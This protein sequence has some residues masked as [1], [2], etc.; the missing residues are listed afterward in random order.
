[1]TQRS[2][3][4]HRARQ[5][6]AP[7]YGGP[8]VLETIEVD[9]PPAGPGEVTVEVRAVG[10]NPTDYKGFSGR[11]SS[12][13]AA[14]PI[15]PGYE[16]AGVV[17]A[18]GADTELAS[19]GG[20]VGDEVLAFRTPGGGYS[21]AITLAA[22]DVFAKPATLGF[23]EAANLLLAGST[24]ADMLRV[25]PPTAGATVLVHGASGAV[26]V[27]LLQLLRTRGVHAVGT[28]SPSRSDEVRRFGG[29]PVT[30]GDGLEDR[31]RALAPQGFDAAYDCVG[32]DEAVDVS[33]ALVPKER[34]VTIA[35]Q[36]RAHRDG[37]AAV[38][39]RDPESAAFRDS[40][41]A[42]LIALA[43]SGDLVVPVAGTYPLDR[44]AEALTRLADGHPGGKIALIP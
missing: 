3:T 7:R 14:L 30:Y 4:Q 23:P 35:A 27:L 16:V 26:G 33:L 1:M 39:G 21:S 31:A 40:V 17:T 38:G 5:V 10:V 24:A 29:D 6:V 8:E 32:T 44:A 18:L 13:P 22:A 28:A 15:R 11:M 9:V 37:F 2:V 41:R 19:G 25:V 12:D 36:A 34:F 43:G 42:E 20:A